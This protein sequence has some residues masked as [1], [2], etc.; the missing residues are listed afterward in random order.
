M[1][2]NGWKTTFFLGN[3]K[4]SKTEVKLGVDKFTLPRGRMFYLVCCAVI[5]VVDQAGYEIIMNFYSYQNP[6]FINEFLPCRP[7]T[8]DG[9]EIPKEQP[10]GMVLIPFIKWDKLP[11]STGDR[12]ISEPSTVG[13]QSPTFVATSK[14][15]TN[16][17][18]HHQ[19]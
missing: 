6:N 16:C 13:L 7:D 18:L 15:T 5:I 14:K 4:V 10:P 12:R 1:K 2:I 19:Q 17:R 9:S 8:V 3:P 11:T